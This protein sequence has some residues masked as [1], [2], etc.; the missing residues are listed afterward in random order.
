MRRTANGTAENGALEPSAMSSWAAHVIGERVDA[1]DRA[2]RA[3]RRDPSSAR[4]L[5]RLRVAARRLRVALELIGELAGA[6][7]NDVRSVKRIAEK[8]GRLRDATVAARLIERFRE[9]HPADD[10]DAVRVLRRRLRRTV[11][12]ESAKLRRRLRAA[13]V[14]TPQ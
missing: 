1:Y 13:V 10:E 4:A 6:G 2:R 11:A 12:R 14:R 5:H 7:R 9:E 3:S 8:T